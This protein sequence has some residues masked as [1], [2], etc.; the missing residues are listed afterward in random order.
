MSL[1][2][3]SK[4]NTECSAESST[5]KGKK[6]TYR[7]KKRLIYIDKNEVYEGEVDDN[8]VREGWG[9][10]K[11]TNGDVYEGKFKGGI[12][13]GKGEYVYTDGSYYRG[14]WK[15]DKKNGYGTFKFNRLE[16]DGIWEND[17]FK[18]GIVFRV[19]KFETNLAF[20]N[21]FLNE[22]NLEKSESVYDVFDEFENLD[23]NTEISNK[24]ISDKIDFI[25]KYIG[26]YDIEVRKVVSAKHD[27]SFVNKLL[28]TTH[29]EGFSDHL[30]GCISKQNDFNS[31]LCENIRKY[32]AY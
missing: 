16:Y 7:R 28:G 31:C 2:S 18:D 3:G 25:K 4:S 20:R 8:D 24:T 9:I 27:D 14:D 6:Y 5:D 12:K 13:E 1:Y 22:A 10:Y 21:T 26:E 23:V 19:N 11:Y 15:N 30:P 29:H 32:I 17:E